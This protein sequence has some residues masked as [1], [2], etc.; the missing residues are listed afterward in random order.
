VRTSEEAALIRGSHLSNGAKAILIR[1]KKKE[2]T[3]CLV[4]MSAS[5]KLNTKKL[6]KELGAN[7]IN[8]AD[9]SE[10]KKITGVLPGAVPPFG[11]VF[12][13]QTY[14]DK[15]LQSVTDIDFN[16]GLRT[17]SL[18]MKQQDYEKVEKP[19]ICDVSLQ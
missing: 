12:G 10:V 15:S 18:R 14:M 3:F 7:S 2:Q 11:S 5:F 4:V 16:A 17:D 8:F 9:T 19:I 1:A 6:R 13:I